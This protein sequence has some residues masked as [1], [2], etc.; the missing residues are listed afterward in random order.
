MSQENAPA[1][2]PALDDIQMLDHII[3]WLDAHIGDRTQCVT[4]K[5]AFISNIDPSFE[6][7]NSTTETDSQSDSNQ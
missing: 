3:I 7:S 5:R 4:L 6:I 2:A 1:A